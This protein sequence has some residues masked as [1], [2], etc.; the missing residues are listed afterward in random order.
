MVMPRHLLMA[1]KK[2]QDTI[3]ICPPVISQYAAVGA[4]K[5]G[6]SYCHKHLPAIKL[7]REYFLDKLSKINDICTVAEAKGAFYFFLKIDTKI[8]DL[9]LVKRLIEEYKVATI[10]GSTFGTSDGCYL[11]VAYGSLD[12]KTGKDGIQRLVRGLQE[13]IYNN[14]K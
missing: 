1:V 6:I 13:I 10:P 2:A 7:V 5:T 3:L 8:A 4:L 9:E 14:S 11:R 12:I